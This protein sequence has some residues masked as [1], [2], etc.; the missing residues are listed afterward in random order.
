MEAR[1]FSHHFPN[2]SYSAPP[3]YGAEIS[4]ADILMPDGKSLEHTGVIPDIKMAPTRSDLA[5]NRA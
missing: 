4:Q 5:A 1:F 2:S 3:D